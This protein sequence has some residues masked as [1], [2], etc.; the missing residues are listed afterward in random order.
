MD[1]DDFDKN[2]RKQRFKNKSRKDSQKH[3]RQID[4]EKV[5]VKAYR[6]KLDYN[7]DYLEEDW[8]DDWTAY[9]VD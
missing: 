1:F 9:L 3:Y 2:K 5:K 8:D 4:R 7:P 6:P